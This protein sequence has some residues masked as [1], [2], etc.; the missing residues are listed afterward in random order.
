MRLS[1]NPER[2]QLAQYFWDSLRFEVPQATEDLR[3]LAS[4]T[5]GL[6]SNCCI[7]AYLAKY[8]LPPRYEANVLWDLTDGVPPPAAPCWSGPWAFVEPEVGGTWPLS[9]DLPCFDPR[10]H[11]WDGY[12]TELNERLH[13]RLMA[14]LNERKPQWTRSAQTRGNVA[15]AVGKAAGE[16][17]TKKVRKA[18]EEKTGEKAGDEVGKAEGA[19]AAAKATK[20]AARHLG[21]EPT[22]QPREV[23]R[24]VR[25]VLRLHYLGHA[26]A[27][28]ANDEKQDPDTVRIAAAKMVERLE[29]KIEPATPGRKTGRKDTRARVRSRLQ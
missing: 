29:L 6:P 13:A 17:V 9:L 5:G 3:A 1:E 18:V 24:D 2:E 14:E 16:A 8:R 12:V 20:A 26:L 11:T 10:L 7:G 19:R 27:R 4:P 25:W 22:G 15:L 23:E 28:I 21:L